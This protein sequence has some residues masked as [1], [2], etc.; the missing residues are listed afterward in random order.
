MIDT[1]V[2]IECDLGRTELIAYNLKQIKGVREV[3][4]ING[5]YD[6]IVK[7]SVESKKDLDEAYSKIRLVNGIKTTITLVVY[8]KD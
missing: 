4:M 6:I 2:L 5:V 8:T 1:Y 7:M 3:D